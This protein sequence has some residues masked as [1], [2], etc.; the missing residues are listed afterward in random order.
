MFTCIYTYCIHIYI[1]ICIGETYVAKGY[2]NQLVRNSLQF[3]NHLAPRCHRLAGKSAGKIIEKNGG[4]PSAMFEYRCPGGTRSPGA[5][6]FSAISCLR[7]LNP[8]VW[9]Q[10]GVFSMLFLCFRLE[11]QTN[12]Q[13]FPY[14]RF[15]WR[16]VAQPP[17]QTFNS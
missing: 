8:L 4:F 5:C 14:F 17:A 6:F 15:V 1:Y 7:V 10:D 12:R 3:A 9:V 13:V 2:Q 16:W 11:H